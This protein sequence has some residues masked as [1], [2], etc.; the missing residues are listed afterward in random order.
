VVAPARGQQALVAVVALA[1]SI[2][3][4]CGGAR[5]AAPARAPS[6]KASAAPSREVLP[7]LEDDYPRALAEAKRTGRP[8]FVDA[9]A[10]WCHS[11]QSM[12]AFVLTD[13][14]LAPLAEEFVWLAIDTDREQN[15]AFVAAFPSESWPTLWVIDPATESPVLKW[16]GTATAE[17]L[18]TLLAAARAPESAEE[19]IAFVRANQ[20]AAR[21][22]VDEAEGGYREILASAGP[23]STARP[24]A[25]EGLALLLARREAHA[26]CA[27]LAASEAPHLPPGTSRAALLVTGLACARTAK[28]AELGAKL[29]A[30]AEAAARDADPRTLTDDRSALYEE[31][32]HSK[33]ELGDLVGARATATEWAALLEREAARAP[34]RRARAVFDP[35]RLAAYVALGEAL[36]AV[37][38]LEDSERS[39]PDDYNPPARLAAA[40][41][42]L[43]R[44]DEARA[45]IG[46]AASR[47]YGARSLRVFQLAADIARAR[48]DR[49]EEAAAL[50]EGLERTGK[51][52]LSPR[53]KAARTT[54]AAR[55]EGLGAH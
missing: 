5:V 21:G 47:V 28:E 43:G 39:F 41:L 3:A 4:A 8:L 19:A 32:V 29:S 50:R 48:G 22:D 36:R 20:A 49:A 16:E 26:E 10:P 34:S 9:W 23:A 11:C 44:L 15:A 33:R 1:A 2:A 7:F 13:A 54:M 37:P 6:A 53:Q 42:E 52:V 31:L 14:S 17:E 35:H 24:R 25:A 30:L 45:A 27:E 12:R 18:V 38:M 51:S 55:L 40:Y 46:R